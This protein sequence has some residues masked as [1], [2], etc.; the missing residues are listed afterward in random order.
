MNYV[1]E[2]KKKLQKK[3]DEEQ[4]KAKKEIKEHTDDI[5]GRLQYLLDNVS[6]LKSTS[7]NLW[8]ELKVKNRTKHKQAFEE[9]EKSLK[10]IEDLV[11]LGPLDEVVD[12]LEDLEEDKEALK[13]ASISDLIENI[14]KKLC[15][16]R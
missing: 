2:E 14:S 6:N 1:E 12:D 8:N 7:A 15:E 5:V 11:I 3:F 16:P 13:K 10:K 9:I 4:Q